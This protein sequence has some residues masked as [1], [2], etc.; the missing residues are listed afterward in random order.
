M[1]PGRTSEPFVVHFVPCLPRKSGGN[2]EIPEGYRR[3]ARAYIR[4]RGSIYCPMPA[5]QKRRKPR[6]LGKTPEGRQGVHPT[7]WQCI[8]PR[9]R[10]IPGTSG[11]IS[12]PLAVHTVP[13]LLRKRGGNQGIPEGHRRDYIRFL[14]M[15]I[16]STPANQKRRKPRNPGGTSGRTSAPLVLHI[17]PR[18][19]CKSGGK[20]AETKGYRRD[21][22]GTPGPTSAF[23]ECTLY[24]RAGRTSDPWQCTLSYACHAKAAESKEYRRDT[25][26]E[27]LRRGGTPE[28]HRRNT[29]RRN[30]GRRDTG[31]RDTGGTPEGHQGE[32][33]TPWQITLAATQK[34]R[35]PRTTRGTPGRT[36]DPLAVHIVP[37][38]P[39]KI[40]GDQGTGGTPGRTSDSL[41]E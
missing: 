10:G 6:N 26:G 4:S 1:T 11:R 5:T 32:H 41:S 3:D 31:G 22:R 15:H 27:E 34:R 13:R 23:W 36:S 20:E 17:I 18:L 37:Y 2:Q 33:P 9:K 14:E 39:R 28:G 40:G 7:P 38:L 21:T 16:D 30:T 29:G 8:L 35:K 25:G 24:A 19:P 12:D